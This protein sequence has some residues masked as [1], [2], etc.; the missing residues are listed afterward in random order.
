VQQIPLYRE[1]YQLL[2]APDS[3]LGKHDSVTWAQV[4]SIPLCLLT[5]DTQTRRIIDGLLRG[6]GAEPAPT[7]ESNATIVL[8][9]HVQTGRWSSVLPD[10]LA[11]TLGKTNMVRAIPIVEPEVTHNV[12]IVV[13]AREPMTPLVAALVV[14]ARRMGAAIPEMLTKH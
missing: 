8:F 5:S 12:G 13:P 3:P 2:T 11:Q 4:G 9:S 10:K 14:E 1:R 7:L 6:A